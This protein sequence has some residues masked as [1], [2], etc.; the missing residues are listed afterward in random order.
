MLALLCTI[1]L[2]AD[3]AVERLSPQTQLPALGGSRESTRFA[4]AVATAALLALKFIL[5]IHFD[6]FGW[7]FY[8]A[9]ILTAALVF[10]ALQARRG[11]GLRDAVPSPGHGRSASRSAGRLRRARGDAAGLGRAADLRPQAPTGRA[12]GD[13]TTP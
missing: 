1:A 9:V 12:S 5:N 7:G 8:L 3:L 6:L 2:I 11:A 4:L 10:L 13:L